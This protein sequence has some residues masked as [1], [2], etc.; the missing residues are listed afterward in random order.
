MG[1]R[2][3][4][5]PSGA[6]LSHD[7][8]LNSSLRCATV[9]SDKAGS[10]IRASFAV[11]WGRSTARVSDGSSGSRYNY[12]SSRGGGGSRGSSSSS[13]RNG[14]LATGRHV[15]GGASG[16][17]AEVGDFSKSSWWKGGGYRQS[18]DRYATSGGWAKAGGW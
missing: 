13:D 11:V 10:S 8:E 5:R 1:S 16:S 4:N 9:M 17:Y 14:Y 6:R 12:Q 3:I 18:P 15:A 2:N 7:D